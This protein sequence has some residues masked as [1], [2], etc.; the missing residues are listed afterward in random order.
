LGERAAR[1]CRN[2]ELLV[3]PLLGSQCGVTH[4]TG[5]NSHHVVDSRDE[6]LAITDLARACRLLNCVNGLIDK[7][8]GNYDFNLDLWNKAEGFSVSR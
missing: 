1:F 2:S 3:E 7:T 8:D 4:L 6:N 5:A